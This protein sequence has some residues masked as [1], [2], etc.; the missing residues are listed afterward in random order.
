M[1][2]KKYK[3]GDIVEE[4]WGNPPI[5]TIYKIMTTRVMVPISKNGVHTGEYEESK[6]DY[7]GRMLK[8]GEWDNRDRVLCEVDLKPSDYVYVEKKEEPIVEEPIKE[9]WTEDELK[10]LLEE[11]LDDWIELY[12]KE[13]CPVMNRMVG[14]VMKNSKGRANPRVVKRILFEMIING[15]FDKPTVDKW[16]LH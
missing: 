13:H 6:W 11:N 3:I 15:E 1:K 7:F 5:Y 14:L 4:T 12:F 9:E 10:E 16:V 2:P 8:D